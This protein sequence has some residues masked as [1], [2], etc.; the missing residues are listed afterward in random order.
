[1]DIGGLSAASVVWPVQAAARGATI[2]TATGSTGNDGTG[3]A[4]QGLKAAAHTARPIDP[5]LPTGPPPAFT[6]TPLEK[7]GDWHV[8]LSRLSAKGYAQV[9]A[10]APLPDAGQL[11][12]RQ[13]AGGQ[14]TGSPA[15]AAGR[16]M[17]SATPAAASK[18][19]DPNAP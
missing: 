13:P 5:D 11:A 8:I 4:D 16:A 2:D 15:E 18:P 9:Q 19:A 3:R 6:T 7:E 10:M 1:M 14:A 17:T 12:P